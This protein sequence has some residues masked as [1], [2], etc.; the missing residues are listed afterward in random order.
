MSDFDSLFERWNRLPA[1]HQREVFPR[2]LGRIEGA[3]A[4]R[5]RI[6]TAEFARAFDEA[7]RRAES[8]VAD[9]LPCTG[10][11]A[12]WLES[13]AGRRCLTRALRDL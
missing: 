10:S 5:G 11:I 1:E 12:A 7:I 2:L 9:S 8:H 13:P 4:H 3:L 6:N